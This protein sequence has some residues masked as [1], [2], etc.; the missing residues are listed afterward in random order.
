MCTHDAHERDEGGGTLRE[1]ILGEEVAE[2]GQAHRGAAE[3]AQP[4]TYEALDGERHDGRVQQHPRLEDDVGDGG[5]EE[6]D[7]AAERVAELTDRRVDEELQRSGGGGP[8]RHVHRDAVV[9]AADERQQQLAARGEGEHRH[10]HVDRAVGVE[11]LERELDRLRRHGG[12]LLVR[13]DWR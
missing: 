1:L 5:D 10:G 3:R 12:A 7:P 4:V 6:E 2:H 13:H 11:R 9:V 8:A